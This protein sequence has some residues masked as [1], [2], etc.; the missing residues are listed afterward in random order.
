MRG[1]ICTLCCGTEREE[2]VSCPL[3]CSY[4]Q[5]AHEIEREKAP[6]LA[7]GQISNP[8]IKLSDNFL[9]ENEKL[10]GFLG[11][12]VREAA[13]E[14]EGAIDNDVRE[15]LNALIATYRT[16]QSGIYYE[17][18]PQNPLAANVCDGVREDLKE[19]EREHKI[20]DASI[21][22]VIVFLQRI[23]LNLN[24]GRKKGRAFIDFLH[25]F[26]ALEE[27]EESPLIV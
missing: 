9:E 22:G 24:N 12:S 4:L 21:L 1:D 14:T 7:A 3:D 23:E 17:S 27:P 8:D 16:L 10:L 2:T 19:F 25:G 26:V 20:R 18:R 11:S 13:L 5:Q 15:A 6:G